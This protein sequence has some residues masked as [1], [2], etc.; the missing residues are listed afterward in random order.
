MAKNEQAKTRPIDMA[1]EIWGNS[2]LLPDW[3][4]HVLKK[5]QSDD[6]KP[7]ARWLCQ[8]KSPIVPQGEIGDVYVSDIKQD[9]QAV[10]I[11]KGCH[12]SLNTD[13]ARNALS[14]YGHGYICSDCGRVEAAKGDFIA[15]P[16]DE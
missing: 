11:C 8:V 4:W 1:Y 15:H 9:A 7:G 6:T 2:P 12:E 5:W 3:E 14:R 16:H 10:R 13:I